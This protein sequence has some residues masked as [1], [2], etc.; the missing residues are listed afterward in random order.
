MKVINGDSVQ[1]PLRAT[2][3]PIDPRGGI[4]V[5][6]RIDD[7]ATNFIVSTFNA[8]IGSIRERAAEK[9]QPVPDGEG[10]V[11]FKEDG[12]D[13]AAKFESMLEAKG[14]P[15]LTQE[16]RDI[17]MRKIAS[18]IAKR[19]A[20]KP[21]SEDLAAGVISAEIPAGLRH[22]PEEMRERIEAALRGVFADMGDDAPEVEIA[23]AEVSRADAE[24]MISGN[25]HPDEFF[26]KKLKIARETDYE[27]YHIHQHHNGDVCMSYNG[28][29]VHDVAEEILKLADSYG[30]PLT[31]TTGAAVPNAVIAQSL[32]ELFNEL[33]NP[34]GHAV[35]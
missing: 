8:I 32:I 9:G 22:K 3:T 6:M 19:R 23:H 33:S 4:A 17:I 2:L 30:I 27:G 13:I 14:G 10:Y 26:S 5:D 28:D 34:N 12:S 31:D 21:Q 35:H 11:A 20:S 29:K 1:E 7:M 16:Q 25:I 18:L 24:A 15:E